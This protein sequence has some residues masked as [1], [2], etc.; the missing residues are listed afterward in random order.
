MLFIILYHLPDPPTLQ[1]LDALT[2]H[3]LYLEELG[4]GR[5]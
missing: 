1:A 5:F 2:I 3:Y 4:P